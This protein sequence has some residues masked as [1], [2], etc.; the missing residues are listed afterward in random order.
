MCLD[1]SLFG[2]KQKPKSFIFIFIYFSSP[3]TT[4]CGRAAGNAGNCVGVE[5]GGEGEDLRDEIVGREQSL[6]VNKL[7][8]FRPFLLAFE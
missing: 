2:V 3:V 4:Q 5:R 7:T 1:Y 6:A 8:L